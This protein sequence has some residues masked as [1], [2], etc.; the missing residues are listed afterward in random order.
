M[1]YKGT[2]GRVRYETHKI[3]SML[4]RTDNEQMRSYIKLVRVE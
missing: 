2:K 1:T 4:S 3:V